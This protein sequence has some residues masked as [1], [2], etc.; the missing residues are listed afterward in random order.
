MPTIYE[1]TIEP[2]ES[3][4]HFCITCHD[5]EKYA[6]DRFIQAAT[7]TNEETQRLRLWPYGQ[8]AIG[9]K[10]FSFLDGPQYTFH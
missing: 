10:L 9:Q 6:H 3:K 5:L 1:V 8:L 4:N 7:I 2:A